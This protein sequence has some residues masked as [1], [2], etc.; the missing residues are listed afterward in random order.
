M[1]C[2]SPEW[3]L[4]YLVAVH[5]IIERDPRIET[6]QQ[7]DILDRYR[8]LGAGYCKCCAQSVWDILPTVHERFAKNVGSTE[9]RVILEVDD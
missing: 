7:S 4:E 9:K 8:S 6:F 1:A 2:L 3:F 5:A